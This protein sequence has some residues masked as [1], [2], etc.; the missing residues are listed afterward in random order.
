M[1]PK[2]KK[3]ER[4]KWIG[5]FLLAYVAYIALL[6]LTAIEETE[7][8]SWIDRALALSPIIPLV[9]IGAIFIYHFKSL[10]EFFQRQILETSSIVFL[11][12]AL[13][14]IIYERLLLL[15]FPSISGLTVWNLIATIW[16]VAYFLT[17]WMKR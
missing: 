13:G 4:A 7:V 17:G 1:I 11:V 2:G 14:S 6:K 3:L 5:A 16:L 10:D 12:I 8:L 15:G 9:L